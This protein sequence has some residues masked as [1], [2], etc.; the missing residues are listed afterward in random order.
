MVELDPTVTTLRYK[1]GPCAQLDDTELASQVSLLLASGG[2]ER[3]KPDHTTGRNRYGIPTFPV[4]DEISFSSTTANP[5][6]PKSFSRAQGALG[7]FLAISGSS[8]PSAKDEWFDQIRSR[9]SALFDADAVC[10][11]APSGTDCE[12]VALGLAL[13]GSVRP[14]TNIFLAPEE[15]GKGVPLAAAGRHYQPS[16]ALGAA[17]DVGA[18]IEGFSA[19]RLKI[20]SI[21]IRDAEGHARIPANVNSDAVAVVRHEIADGRDVLLHVLDSS[22]AG[23]SG[24]WRSTAQ[25]LRCEYGDRVK[26]LIDACQ[27][28]CNF[29][30]IQQDLQDGFAVIVTGSK[31]AGGPPFCGALLLPKT[32]WVESLGR[33]ALPI[34]L[35]DYCALQDWPIQLRA[36]VDS[37]LTRQYNLGLA[38][39]WI[40]ALET[41]ELYACLDE[42]LTGRIFQRFR[43]EV[44]SRA[45]QLGGVEVLHV[46]SQPSSHAHA[47]VSLAI[48]DERGMPAAEAAAQKLQVALRDPKL[49]TICH[50]GQPVKVGGK[51]ALRIA[52]SARDVVGV[53]AA[54][55]A[56]ASL[57]TALRPLL[58]NLETLLS[59]WDQVG[60][61]YVASAA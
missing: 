5:I 15:T 19:D 61:R 3:I 47:I 59:K 13:S 6:S 9:I 12:V 7:N 49:G 37:V 58:A 20:R 26:V 24:I 30:Q 33:T 60:R 55:A 1:D 14:I 27:L 36:F 4:E 50:V 28:R 54:L 53:T 51:V 17:V 43:S 22:K 10:V 52:P 44:V 45:S 2:D 31:F 29:S 41:L 56:G 23:L 25:Q 16:T 39:R 42:T 57:E 18:S 35:R 11:M 32:P 46:T 38:L 40:A 21:E 34:G 48:V 8:W